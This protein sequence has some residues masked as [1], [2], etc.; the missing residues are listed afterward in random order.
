MSRTFLTTLLCLLLA[1]CNTS[2]STAPTL[3]QLAPFAAE[4]RYIIAVM[5]FEFKGGV[6]EQE[7]YGAFGSRLIDKAMVELFNT[8]RFR[9]VERSRI[10]AVL[11]EI[12]LGQA[13][14]VASEMAAQV[15]K[16]VGAEMVFIGSITSIRQIV[17]KDTVGIAH[18]NTRGFEVGMSGRL[19]D[20]ALGELVAVG[21][22]TAGEE[23]TIKVAMGAQSGSIDPDETLLD[24]AFEKALTALIND[25][26]ANISPK[27]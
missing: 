27:P 3:K 19:V 8:K 9:V 5:P 2:T 21:Q 14:V 6:E 10:S 1:A 16:Q 12:K 11:G 22:A 23:Q 26:A 25:L 4:N 13:G 20:I 24:K 18:M 15:G 7:K 17:S